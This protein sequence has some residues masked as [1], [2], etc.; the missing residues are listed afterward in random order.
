[1]GECLEFAL[2]NKIIEALCAYAMIDKP[3]GF[4]KLAL[5]TIS[6][7]ISSVRSISLLSNSAV[8]PGI[9]QLLRC[10]CRNLSSW[11]FHDNQQPDMQAISELEPYL[12]EST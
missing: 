10:I 1:M 11:K 4:F 7:V 5:E 8:H 2:R 3:K 12:F 6:E 9:T